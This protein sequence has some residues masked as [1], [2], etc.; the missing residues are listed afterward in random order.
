[1][2]TTELWCWRR[3]VLI[4]I[5]NLDSHSHSHSH[6]DSPPQALAAAGPESRLRRLDVSSNGLDDQG[7][8]A[9]RWALDAAGG[10]VVELLMEGNN[11]TAE[12]RPGFTPT[13][14]TGPGWV[15]PQS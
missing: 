1:M 12:A 13:V 8:E 6:R 7:M 11:D 9:L 3:R 5:P 2:A 10:G 14:S 15:H 4:L